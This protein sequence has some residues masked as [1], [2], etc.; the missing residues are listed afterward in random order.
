VTNYLTSEAADDTLGQIAQAAPGSILLFTYI[1]RGVLDQPHRFFGAAKMMAR[2]NS[3][4][5]PWT[6]GL[7]P[8]EIESYLAARGLRL[9]KDL[10][11]AEVWNGA[12]RSSAGTHGYEFYRLASAYVPGSLRR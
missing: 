12:G 8:E 6:F 1:H 3:Y 10:G 7:Y 2:L 4:G 9:M 11:V 5:E